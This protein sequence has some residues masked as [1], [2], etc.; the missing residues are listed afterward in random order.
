MRFLVLISLGCP[1]QSVDKTF[2]TKNNVAIME[3]NSVKPLGSSLILGDLLILACTTL[4]VTTFTL[5][6]EDSKYVRTYGTLY[7][8]IVYF[9]HGL[10]SVY[11][12][13][14]GSSTLT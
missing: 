4:V 2:R 14:L 8:I 3:D 1:K 6:L 10:C 7:L 12:I 13:E 5:R 11:F 9:G